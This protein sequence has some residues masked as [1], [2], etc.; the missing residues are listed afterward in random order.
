[1]DSAI[2]TEAMLGSFA[3]KVAELDKANVYWQASFAKGIAGETVVKLE[4]RADQ[5]MAYYDSLEARL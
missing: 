4:W 3:R 2:Y 5:M 1:M